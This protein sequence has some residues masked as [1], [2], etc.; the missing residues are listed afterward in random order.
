MDGVLRRV[1]EI[2]GLEVEDNRK[3]RIRGN[4]KGSVEIVAIRRDR[5]RDRERERETERDYQNCLSY[6]E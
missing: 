1:R 4:S 3:G 2:W 6:T 5:D